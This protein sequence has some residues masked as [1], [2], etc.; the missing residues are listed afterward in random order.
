MNIKK[1]KIKL[2]AYLDGELDPELVKEIEYYINHNPEIR[3]EYERL[4]KINSLLDSHQQTLTDPFFS[5]RLK[6]RLQ[7]T[8]QQKTMTLKR[9]NWTRKLL[10]PASV[11]VGLVV[12][13]LLGV[14]I[15][16]KILDADRTANNGIAQEYFGGKVLTGI[17]EGSITENYIKLSSQV[18]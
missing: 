17:P 1:I 15:Q 18:K 3:S 16:D 8:R 6:V 12:G 13:M 11:I 14:E 7:R 10:L 5:T 2:S 9:Y 4:Q